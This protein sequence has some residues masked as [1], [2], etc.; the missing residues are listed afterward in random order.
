MSHKFKIKTKEN[1]DDLLARVKSE[2]AENDFAFSG[3]ASQ[4]RFSGSGVT[5]TYEFEDSEILITIEKSPMLLPDSL[6]EKKIRNYFQ[7]KRTGGPAREN[8]DLR[9]FLYDEAQR[10]LLFGKAPLGIN[11]VWGYFFFPPVPFASMTA[12][13]TIGVTTLTICSTNLILPSMNHLAFV[14]NET[15]KITGS[16]R[17]STRNA[18]LLRWGRTVDSTI[19]LEM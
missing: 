12:S 2:A 14:P 15:T 7:K 13:I 18:N 1:P 10:P 5:G 19:F 8:P 17:K 6:I 9:R 4:G 11:G 16:D 3:D